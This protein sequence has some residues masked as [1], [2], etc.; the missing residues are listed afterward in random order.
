MFARTRR[1]PFRE[2]I[3]RVRSSIVKAILDP[4]ILEQLEHLELIINVAYNERGYTWPVTP[5]LRKAWSTRSFAGSV[6][7][8]KI[9]RG[10]DKTKVL[11]SIHQMLL[12]RLYVL[13]LILLAWSGLLFHGYQTRSRGMGG[14]LAF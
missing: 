8:T 5:M 4:D 3:V 12:F 10:S 6:S 13:R 11:G 9:D 1:N 2:P 7:F 14:G